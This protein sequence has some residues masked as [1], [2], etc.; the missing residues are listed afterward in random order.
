MTTIQWQPVV[1]ALTKPQSYRI[2]IVPRSTSG[3]DNMAADI[4]A[5]HPNYNAD[6][7]R[8]LAPLIMDW[9]GD[10]LLNGTQVNLEE[11]FSF[12]LTCSGRLAGPDDPLPGGEDILHVRVYPSRTFV[13]AIRNA[14]KLERL[15]MSEKLPLITSAQDT[16]LK[17]ADVLN[18]AGVL[19][20]T[21]SNLYFDEED[22]DCGCIITGTQSGET[23]QSTFASVANSE[24]LL[25]PEIPAQANPWNNEYT[26][27]I[28]TQYTAHGTPRTG[29]YRRRLRTPLTVPGLGLPVPPETGILTDNS[30]AA[31]VSINAG[32]LT[33]DERLRI[34]VILDQAADRL[35]F[36]L[37]DMKEDGAAGAEVPVAADGE[38]ILPGFS[39]SAVS[40]LE[41]TVNNYAGLKE[42]VHDCYSGRLVDILDVKLA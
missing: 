31:Y 28:T 21:G 33:A 25:V 7:I 38:Y 37:I 24:I 30:A 2:Q 8:S 29:I 27:S 41:L 23:K 35:L 19:R 5:A 34:Q 13:Q 42:M 11:A 18:P 10:K 16:K 40:T 14:A 17:L 4:S 26:V 1:N 15:P 20:L 39:G 6:L 9:I 3:Y 12:R 32:T 36:N 22:P